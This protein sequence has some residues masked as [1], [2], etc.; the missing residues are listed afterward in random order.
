MQPVNETIAQSTCHRLLAECVATRIEKLLRGLVPDQPRQIHRE[1]EA[2][3]E[4]EASEVRGE[5]CR[6]RHN[7]KVGRQR[8]PEATAN[9]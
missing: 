5:S 6:A 4:C 2:L 9:C 8:E 7:P 3:M 1:A